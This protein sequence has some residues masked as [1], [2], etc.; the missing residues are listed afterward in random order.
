MISRN[1]VMYMYTVFI[2]IL[3]VRKPIVYKSRIFEILKKKKKM[4]NNMEEKGLRISSERFA[5]V[6]YNSR[7]THILYIILLKYNTK[8]CVKIKR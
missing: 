8:S 6:Y 4:E 2:F 1:P 5:V 7:P 3:N